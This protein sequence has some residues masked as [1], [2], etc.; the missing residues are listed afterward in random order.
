MTIKIIL[1]GKIEVE[2]E[3]SN[4]SF[5][6]EEVVNEIINLYRKDEISLEEFIENSQLEIQGLPLYLQVAIFCIIKEQIDGDEITIEN[7]GEIERMPLE[8]Y[9][10]CGVNQE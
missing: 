1:D 5:Y 10:F 3:I 9:L 4:K 2:K 6:V 8:E 7:E